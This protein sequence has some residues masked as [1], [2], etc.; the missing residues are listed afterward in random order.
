MVVPTSGGLEYVGERILPF[1]Q[2]AACYTSSALGIT[3]VLLRHCAYLI[4]SPGL[5]TDCLWLQC[6][7]W[8]LFGTVSL[9]IVASVHCAVISTAWICVQF[10]RKCFMGASECSLKTVAFCTLLMVA[11]GATFAVWIFLCLLPCLLCLDATISIATNASVSLK[12]HQRPSNAHERM[13]A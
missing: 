4:F 1:W 2:S 12:V 10:L 9:H 5:F 13:C 6:C 7:I 3:K 8:F 11:F